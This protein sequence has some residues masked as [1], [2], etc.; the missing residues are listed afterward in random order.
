SAAR[1]G[2]RTPDRRKDSTER[3]PGRTQFELKGFGME[4]R[5][6]HLTQA[7]RDAEREFR[8]GENVALKIGARGDL[9][10]GHA[11]TLEPQD[12]ALG[13][14]QDVLSLGDGARAREGNLLDRVDQLLDLALL[15]D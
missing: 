10:D 4:Q 3:L 5:G 9:G 2:P 12:A 1:R 11:F 8:L 7:V 13:D 14:I 6:V 15:Q